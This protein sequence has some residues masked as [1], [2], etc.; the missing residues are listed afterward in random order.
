MISRS[1]Y[2][3]IASIV[4]GVIIVIVHFIILSGGIMIIYIYK[5]LGIL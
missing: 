1:L 3:N 4:G 2:C 5:K